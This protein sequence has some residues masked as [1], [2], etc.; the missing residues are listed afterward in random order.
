MDPSGAGVPVAGSTAM[1]LSSPIPSS[2]AMR[3]IVDPEGSA[4]GSA[5]V[6]VDD[7]V[8]GLASEMDGGGAA[9]AARI[10]SAKGALH[11]RKRVLVT[12]GPFLT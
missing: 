2:A 4:V 3:R 1:S 9:H 11:Q 7:R 8:A 6:E 5:A 12:V 10:I